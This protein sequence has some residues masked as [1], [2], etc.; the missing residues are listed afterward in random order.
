MTKLDSFLTVAEAAEL[1]GVS[2]NTVRNW[3]KAGK[4][5]EYRHPINNYRLFKSEELEELLE[6]VDQPARK[7]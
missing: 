3:G 6:E 4:I 7:K 1:L 5:T 2:S